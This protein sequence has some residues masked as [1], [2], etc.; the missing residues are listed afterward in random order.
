[1]ESAEN[2]QMSFASVLQDRSRLYFVEVTAGFFLVVAEDKQQAI[3]LVEVWHPKEKFLK[4]KVRNATQ[5]DVEWIARWGG[6]VPD[7]EIPIEEQ[8]NPGWFRPSTESG[9]CMVCDD[10]T[11]ATG[12][13]CQSTYDG[14]DLGRNLHRN[15]HR[16]SPNRQPGRI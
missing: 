3:E 6:I 10:I 11:Q 4:N 13:P 9:Y 5:S 14:E 8:Q 12:N 16:H 15:Y 7:L 1:M 2:R